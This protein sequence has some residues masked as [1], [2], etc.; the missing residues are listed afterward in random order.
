ME[1]LRIAARA[2][3]VDWWT[4]NSRVWS[5]RRGEKVADAEKDH[6]REDDGQRKMLAAGHGGVAWVPLERKCG[7]ETRK[8][9]KGAVIDTR[10]KTGKLQSRRK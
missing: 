7:G 10:K 2:Q 5:R 8:L 4:V 9:W 3:I 1:A 6:E